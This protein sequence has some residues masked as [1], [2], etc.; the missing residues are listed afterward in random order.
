MSTWILSH[1]LGTLPY[2]REIM[3]HVC[4]GCHLLT[5]CLLAPRNIED[6]V[7]EQ[8]DIMI[9]QGNCENMQHYFLQQCKAATSGIFGVHQNV[10]A[11]LQKP[12]LGPNSSSSLALTCRSGVQRLKQCNISLN[13]DC[14][15]SDIPW[16]QK[17]P[18]LA[19]SWACRLA[20][21]V[22]GNVLHLGFMRLVECS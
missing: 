1:P 4:M 15:G 11:S 9:M 17:T 6:R 7:S 5:S 19:G 21:G 3:T 14:S 8:F 13:A 10:E 20:F 22:D 2:A 16:Q 12:W 18:T